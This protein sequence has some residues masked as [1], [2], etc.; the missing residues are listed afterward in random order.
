MSTEVQEPQLNIDQLRHM[1]ATRV[2]PAVLRDISGA[3]ENLYPIWRPK[4]VFPDRPEY[5][6]LRRICRYDHRRFAKEFFSHYCQDPFSKMHDDFFDNWE[7]DHE[8][9]GL[10]DV[11]AAPRGNAKTTMRAIIKTAHDCVY[12][13]EEYILVVSSKFDLARDK[14]RDIRDELENNTKFTAVYGPQVGPMWNLHDFITAQGVRVRATGYRATIRGLLWGSKRP[15]K[16]ILDDAEDPEHVDSETQRDK[17]NKWFMGDI[18]KLGTRTT[19]IEVIGTVL[20]PE[21][22]I[23]QLLKNPGYRHAL[24]QAVIAYAHNWPLWEQWRQIFVNLDNPDRIYDARIFFEEHEA[25]MLEGAEVLWPEHESYYDLMVQCLVE[26]DTAFQLEKQNNPLPPELHLFDMQSAG[27]FSIMPEQ[28]VR[29]D[30]RAVSFINI[31]DATAFWDPALGGDQGNPD[32]SACPVLWKDNAGYVYIIDAYMGHRDKPDEQISEIV[33]LLWRWQVPKI[34]VEANNFQSLLISDLREA[35]AQRA[36]EEEVDWHIDVVPVKNL[37]GRSKPMRISTLE[38]KVKNK[39]LWFAD[40]LAYEFYRQFAFFRPVKD[41]GK[42]DAP[43]SVEGGIRVLERL[44]D[45]RSAV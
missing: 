14:V 41:A 37:P 9:R 3:I 32:W 18:S 45:R 5:A 26:G 22:L 38:P 39:W 31:V 25:E 7:H 11:T 12:N 44:L 21:S 28:L 36:I 24:Y 33:D 15:S 35:I 20:H 1:I 40:N 6:E 42:D 2:S 30:G 19:N 8:A 4:R 43:D 34:G 29:R 23:M 10:R 13:L 16:I 17:F 27:Y